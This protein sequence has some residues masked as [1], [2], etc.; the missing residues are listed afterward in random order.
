MLVTHA[1]HFLSEC[2]Y[3][4]TMANGKVAEQG[5]YQELVEN[6][7]V[8]SRLIK[9]Y[10]GREKEEDEADEEDEAIEEVKPEDVARGLI[11][12]R[13]KA[14]TSRLRRGAGT[15]KLEG[16]L[17]VAE[18]RTTGSVGWSSRCTLVDRFSVL[19]RDLLLVYGAYL[20]AGQGYWTAPLLVIFMLAM[21]ASQIL[22]SYTLI[23][24]QAKYVP[25]SVLR[26]R[27]SI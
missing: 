20:K 18:K 13:L 16:R 25:L 6:Q 24:W 10:G 4:Y 12:A 22:N 3:V 7:G 26:P 17:I 27:I 23:W 8:F 15:G 11:E 9:E 2:D 1:L 14:E 19:I 5:T 21:Q